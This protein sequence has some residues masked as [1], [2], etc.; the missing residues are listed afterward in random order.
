MPNN[1][2]EPAYPIADI[3]EDMLYPGLTKRE[4]IAAMCLQGMLSN[5]YKGSMGYANETLAIE[6][7]EYADAL[8]VHLE[9]TSK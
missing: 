3:H 5:Q 1:K 7:V 2:N 4:V 9:N 8:L 6:A